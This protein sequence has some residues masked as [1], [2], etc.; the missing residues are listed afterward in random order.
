MDDHDTVLDA[1]RACDRK[2]DELKR[3]HLLVRAEDA[4]SELA[5][6]VNMVLEERR[7]GED[8]RAVPRAGAERRGRR[9]V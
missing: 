7:L 6:T 9:D 5:E 4:F 8:R 3:E 2:L 1:L